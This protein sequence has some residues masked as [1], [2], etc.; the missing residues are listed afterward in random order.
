MWT[1]NNRIVNQT[2][3]TTETIS[4]PKTHFLILCLKR[5][6]MFFWMERHSHQNS[7]FHPLAHLEAA[8]FSSSH[9]EILP[10]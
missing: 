5:E 7:V 6:N 1:S 8:F 10:K 9:P 2:K 4:R 3:W